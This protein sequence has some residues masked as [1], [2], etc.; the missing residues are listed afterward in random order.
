MSRSIAI[1][2]LV[3]S[4]VC[5]APPMAAAIELGSAACKSELQRTNKKMQESLSL[6]DSVQDAPAAAKCPAFSA[7]SELADEIRE[8][9]AR[10]EPPQTRVSAVRDAD[11]VIEA[12]DQ[13]YKKW[14]PP[15]PGMVRVKMTMVTR[16][17]AEKLPKPLAAI[18]KCAGDGDMFSANER[19]DLGRLVMLGCPGIENPTAE[20]IKERNMR[21]DLLKK[22]QVALYVTRDKDGDNPQR[23]TFPIPSAD[24]RE[25]ATDV[26]PASRNHV[27]DKL[28]LIE[29]Y[30]EPAKDGVCRVHAVWRVAE[31][32]AKLILWQ[33]ATDCSKGVGDLKTV[34]ERP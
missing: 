18:H 16:T 11:D 27:G 23:L 14:C 4:A 20:Q 15:R 5:L 3:L 30:W 32:K 28:D 33:E 8:S 19:F 22:E 24:G 6:I 25:T 1:A 13:T 26:L 10:C 7:A 12:I 9:A 34:L 29:S 2:G 21:P 31:A 17:T